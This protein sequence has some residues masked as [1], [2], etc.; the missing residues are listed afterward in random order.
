VSI[1]VAAVGD[2]HVNSTVGLMPPKVRRDDGQ[3]VLQS[4]TQRWL[5]ENWCDFWTL[6]AAMK[7]KLGARVI[8]F[9]N[10]D[11]GDINTHS[12]FQL[13]EPNNRDTVLDI[14]VEAVEP[15]RRACDEIVVIR[16][17]EA[18]V[19][20]VG[21]LENRAA[22]EIGALPNAAEQTHSFYLFRGEVEGVRFTFAHHP[23][24]NSTVPWTAGNEANRRAARDV[25]EYAMRDWVPAVTWWGHYHHWADSGTT[26]RIRAIYNRSWQVKTA[27][28]H[29]IGKSG[30]HSEIGGAWMVL[31]NGA[32]KVRDKSYELPQPEPVTL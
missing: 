25:Y 24:T 6:T 2:L 13:V 12:G 7:V 23:G 29:R 27:F 5:W 15:M 19:G 31:A 3:V 21:W 8:G 20:G 9:L 11:W 22:K 17:T 28:E 32:Y 1:I 18:H 30:D 16:G 4:P 26:H 14:M 10:G